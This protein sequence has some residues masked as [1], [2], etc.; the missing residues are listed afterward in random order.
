M[1]G[2]HVKWKNLGGSEVTYQYGVITSEV[3]WD[4]SVKRAYVY[5]QEDKT[6]YFQPKP[7]DRLQI[8]EIPF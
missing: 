7:V 8:V 5:V 2:I 3:F 1:I 4:G 6:D